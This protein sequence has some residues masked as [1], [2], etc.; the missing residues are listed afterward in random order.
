MRFVEKLGSGDE[1]EEMARL[2]ILAGARQA[3]RTPWACPAQ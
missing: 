1:P 3:E 2:D